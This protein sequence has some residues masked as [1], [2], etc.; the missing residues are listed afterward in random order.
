[1]KKQ[2]T[3]RIYQIIFESNSTRNRWPKTHLQRQHARSAVER[4]RR[5]V[6]RTQRRAVLGK[7]NATALL[8]ATRE[9]QLRR[10]AARCEM[11]EAR[12]GE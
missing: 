5:Q 9:Q 7:R 11:G 10:N 1:M 12:Y 3:A 6:Q 4:R 8:R 2:S